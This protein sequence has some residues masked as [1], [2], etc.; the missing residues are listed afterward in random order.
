MGKGKTFVGSNKVRGAASRRSRGGVPAWVLKSAKSGQTLCGRGLCAPGQR[1]AVSGQR[2]AGPRAG[3]GQ[4]SAVSGRGGG[5]CPTK[6]GA[7]AEGGQR[8]EGPREAEGGQRSE[9]PK[10]AEGGQ[11]SEGGSTQGEASKAARREAAAARA[12]SVA[13][14]HARRPTDAGEESS[15]TAARALAERSD[16]LRRTEA[17]T[18]VPEPAALQRLRCALAQAI[19]K[20]KP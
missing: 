17:P 4:R 7:E 1:S 14:E 11:R 2:S 9:G 10:E 5:E 18:E 8:S 13:T 6:G 15:R 16:P 12:R 19:A 3:P 20:P